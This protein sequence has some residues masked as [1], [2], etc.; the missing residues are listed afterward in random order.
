LPQIGQK[1]Y[2]SAISPSSRKIKFQFTVQAEELTPTTPSDKWAL[3][4]RVYDK[5]A[6]IK[7]V[8]I[9]NP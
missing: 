7:A 9:F 8:W 6:L 1:G 5:P 3:M 4:I 2:L